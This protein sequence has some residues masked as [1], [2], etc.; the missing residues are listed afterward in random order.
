MKKE[1]KEIVEL[2]LG[3]PEA[4]RKQ[5]LIELNKMLPDLSEQKSELAI[6]EIKKE[7]E[8]E[9]G[10]L[11]PHCKSSNIT[12][13]GNYKGRK[14][15][16]CKDCQK[17]FNDL[18]GTPMSGSHYLEK[19]KEYFQCL[20]EGLSLREIKKKLSI[21]LQTS[22]N[23]RH[24]ILNVFEKMGCEKMEG[25]V[26]ADETFFLSSEKGN[27]HITD[28]PVRKRGGV[29]K[30]RGLSTEQIPVL[31]S[32]DRTKH[33]VVGVGS[34]GKI[35]NDEVEKILGNSIEDNSDVTLCSDGEH[36]YTIFSKKHHINHEIVKSK[37]GKRITKK[38]YH[39]QHINNFH[40]RLKSW[41]Q[42]FKGVA[43]KYLAHYI[44]WFR[45]LIKSR[46]IS[47]ENEVEYYIKNS[48]STLVLATN[49]SIKKEFTQFC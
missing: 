45:M 14:R 41:I 38:I 6:I 33:Y 36:S 11:C 37:K 44:H 40:S 9:R 5:I 18:T 13:Y 23:W 27:K 7:V 21:S 24:K 31:T 29:A 42:K 22:F 32:C 12:G 16:K 19:W 20:A 39:I 28:R 43:T 35:K 30:K 34:G 26:E 8:K 17:T 2:L 48:L 10:I 4:E 46:I 1:L 25:I 49:L 3:F 47:N 15:Y